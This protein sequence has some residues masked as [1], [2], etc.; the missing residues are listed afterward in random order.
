MRRREVNSRS[1]IFNLDG[2]SDIARNINEFAVRIESL[3]PISL[4]ACVPSSPGRLHKRNGPFPGGPCR[5][6]R[7]IAAVQS[8][9]SLGQVFGPPRSTIIFELVRKMGGRNPARSKTEWLT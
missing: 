1:A 5:S 2:L 3:R 6:C 4:R 8:R 9:R 7:D